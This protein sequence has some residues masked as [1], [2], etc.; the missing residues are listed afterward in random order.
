[1]RNK[2]I[3]TFLLFLLTAFST[4]G[5]YHDG[6]YIGASRAAYTNEPYYGFS[7]IVIENGNIVDVEFFIRDSSKH[8]NFNEGYEKYFAG[9]DLYV[10]QCRNDWKGIKSYPDT[11]LK[12][13]IIDKV[14]VISGATWSYNIFKALIFP[15]TLTALLYW[16]ST[17]GLFSSICFTSI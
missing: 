1:M 17:A 15:S 16:I 14:D 5:P 8:V 13:Q 6:I 4:D 3:V 11:L 10:Q 2:I 12:Y 9:N 7:K